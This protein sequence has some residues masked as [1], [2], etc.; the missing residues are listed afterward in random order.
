[1]LRE[2]EFR[3]RLR[4]YNPDDVDAFLERV[5]AGVELLEER[6]RHATERAELAEQRVAEEG[7][8]GA[9][10]TL[11]LAQRTAD[12]AVQ[13][14]R[15][16]AARLREQAQAD[17]AE[18]VAAAEGKARCLAEEAQSAIRADVERLEAA[19]DQL[20]H[21]VAELARYVDAERRRA[22]RVLSE[23]ASWLAEPLPESPARPPVHEVDLSGVRSR[24]ERS[25]SDP[26]EAADRRGTLT[27][28]HGG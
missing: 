5:A 23:A 16:E 14:A 22:R 25:A 4:G 8:D 21:D 6:L 26:A 20:T 28:L 13:E 9:H 19:R 24:G 17:A 18:I 27:E 12:L 15:E 11:R 10:R 7:T 3:E 2:V 1:M